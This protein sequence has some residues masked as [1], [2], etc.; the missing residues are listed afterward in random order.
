MATDHIEVMEQVSGEEIRP[1]LG[2]L[3]GMLLVFL[4]MI[5]VCAFMAYCWWFE[6]E[7]IGGKVLTAKAGIVSLLG[8][9]LAI[10]LVLVMFGLL[11]S[12]KRLILGDECLQ[13]ISRDRVVVHIPYQNITET[14]AKGGDGAGVVG[15]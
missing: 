14:Y 6:V 15:M 3:W 2:K 4:L 11:A 12:A 1:A 7:L 8:I 9:P 5:P 13:L 10:L